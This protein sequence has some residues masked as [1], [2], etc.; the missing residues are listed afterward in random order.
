MTKRDDRW[1]EAAFVAD[2][3]LGARGLFKTYRRSAE[4]EVQA[5]CGVDFDL[6]DG[7]ITALLGRSG[8][9]KSTLARCLAFLEEPDRGEITFRGMPVNFRHKENLWRVRRKS[10][11]V[12]QD[13]ARSINPY[14]TVLQALKE[15][16]IAGRETRA[17]QKVKVDTLL[18]QVRLSPSL[19]SMRARNLSGGQA[20]RLALARALATDPEILILDESFSGLDLSLQARWVNLVLEL[21][22]T[23]GLTCLLITHDEDLARQLAGRCIRMADGRIT[24]G[25]KV[26]P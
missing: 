3:A 22:E 8:S 14:F 1:G 6:E 12:F 10:Q 17:N 16:M 26:A 13:P 23:Y 20:Q 11:M 4:D 25:F 15:P 24:S 5:L 18:E 7:E 21:V 19:L 2:A 9:G